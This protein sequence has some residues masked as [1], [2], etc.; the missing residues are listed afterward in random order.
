MKFKTVFLLLCLNFL[1]G[2]AFT[3]YAVAQEVVKPVVVPKTVYA[4]DYVYK[5][6]VVKVKDGDT[7]QVDIDLGFD[8]VMKGIDVRLIGIYAPE[9]F[10]PQTPSEKEAGLKVKQFLTDRLP[11]GKE[12]ILKTQKDNKEKYGRYL[13]SITDEK[14]DVNAAI[15]EFMSSNKI[16]SNK[17]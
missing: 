1:L 7:I 2:G 17:K 11:I 4:F 12:I 16:K 13:G 9:T 14:G 15:L 3:W 5:A 8:I 6:T 10:R